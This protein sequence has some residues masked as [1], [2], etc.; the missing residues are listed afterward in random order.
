[1]SHLHSRLSQRYAPAEYEK[2]V[3]VQCKLIEFLFCQ[4]DVVCGHSFAGVSFFWEGDK[5]E[6][7]SVDDVL[8]F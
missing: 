7:E 3:K 8:W 2:M 5:V 6:R 4:M 1:M